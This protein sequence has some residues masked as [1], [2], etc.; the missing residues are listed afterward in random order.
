[1]ITAIHTYLHSIKVVCPQVTQIALDYIESGLVVSKVSAR[2]L[3][4][5][6]NTMQKEVGFLYSGLIRVYYIEHF[7][8]QISVK[9]IKENEFATHFS[10]FITENPTK[11]YFQCIEPSIIV[12]IPF[13]HIEAGYETFPVLERYG[14]LVAEE[15]LKIHHRRIESFLFDTAEE[16]YLKFMKEHPDLLERIS[17]TNLASYLGVERQTLTRIRKRIAVTGLLDSRESIKTADL[18]P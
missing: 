3:Y 7:G 10:A 18:T 15:A 5:S 9:F 12:K 17:I 11:Y 4:S 1:M 6:P 8:N 16:R 13:S 14:R 2:Q